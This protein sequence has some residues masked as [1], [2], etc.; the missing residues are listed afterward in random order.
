MIGTLTHLSDLCLVSAEEYITAINKFDEIVQQ[1]P[2]TDLALYRQIDALTTSLLMPQDSSLNKGTLGKYSVN[3]LSEYNNKLSE[4][5]KTR[6]KSGLEFEQTLLPTEYT[7]YQNYPNPF[8]PITN[9]KYDLSN[10]TDV[11]LIIYDILGRK[12]KELVNNK[13]QA[14]RY[15]VQFDAWNLASG[16]YIYQ[17]IADKYINSKKMILLK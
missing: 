12:V 6:G 1:N 8:N 2:N 10:A 5:L 14:G 7:L 17:L 3:N 13:Q 4:L 15:D 16:V 11:S 9:I